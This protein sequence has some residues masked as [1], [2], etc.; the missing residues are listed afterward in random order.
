MLEAA[1]DQPPIYLPGPYWRPKAGAAVAQ[2]RRHGLDGF[3]GEKSGLATSYADNLHTDVRTSLDTRKGRAAKF[4]LEKVW[5]FSAIFDAQVALTRGYARDEAALRAARVAESELAHRLLSEYDVGD[6]LLGGCLAAVRID[7]RE[8]ALNHLRLVQLIDRVRGHIDL[9]GVH[10]MFEIGG[11]F[12]ALVQLL[13]QNFNT[14]RK[15]VYL[16]VVPNLY[17]GTCYLRTLFGGAVRD[18]AETADLERITFRDDSSLEI[19]PIAPWQI[20]RLAVDVDL[21][22]NSNSFVEMPR[23]VVANYAGKVLALGSHEEMAI[24]LSTYGGGLSDTLAPA[25]LPGFFPAAASSATSTRSWIIRP[26]SA[27]TRSETKRGG[28]TCSQARAAT[29]RQARSAPLRPRSRPENH[30]AAPAPAPIW[31][32]NYWIGGSDRFVAD[33]VSCL[34]DRPVDITLAG[35]V[36]PAFD[37]WLAERVPE[38]LPRQTV[39]I[40]SLVQSPLRGL[41]ARLLQALGRD[42]A[43]LPPPPAMA[44]IRTGHCCARLRCPRCATPRMAPICRGFAP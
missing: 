8:V 40:S 17:V 6:S 24:V 2:I 32:E 34:R 9:D 30:G 26:A 39:P 31:T 38:A 28:P 27:S 36:H 12:G 13:V 16:D 4:V 21:F 7:G 35:N 19:L 44:S 18:F 23:E 37:A 11:G 43:R 20:E 14:L 22:W 42:R 33:L 41:E 10:S 29:A 3:R 15:V 5:P 25:E 1:R